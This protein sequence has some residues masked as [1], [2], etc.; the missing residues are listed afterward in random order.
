MSLTLSNKINWGDNERERDGTES[1]KTDSLQINAEA[2]G[3]LSVSLGE[4]IPVE[5]DK[6][7]KR[8]SK[9]SERNH[10][11][12]LRHI[13]R[14]QKKARGRYYLAQKKDET[15]GGKIE[16]ESEKATGRYLSYENVAI[17][18]ALIA[19]PLLL[20]ADV[21]VTE[22]KQNVESAITPPPRTSKDFDMGDGKIIQIPINI[23]P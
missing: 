13:E 12:Y 21:L 16:R 18:S 6:E 14:L 11:Y 4:R 9:K 2:A 3:V 8:K 15:S 17:F 1:I 7:A 22:Q 19:V 23:R 5:N 10:Q 20:V